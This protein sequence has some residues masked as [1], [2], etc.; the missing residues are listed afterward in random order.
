MSW[1]E[2]SLWSCFQAS[3]ALDLTNRL[4][5]KSTKRRRLKGTLRK[6]APFG[7]PRRI[8]IQHSKMFR[9]L[10]AYNSKCRKFS[11]CRLPKIGTFWGVGWRGARRGFLRGHAFSECPLKSP[12]FGTFLGEA[13]KVH[14]VPLCFAE[15][16]TFLQIPFCGF[17]CGKGCW[18]VILRKNFPEVL[19]NLMNFLKSC[20]L[21]KS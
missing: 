15:R 5:K 10:N 21:R 19:W 7:I 11:L 9:F 6:C 14:T 20:A 16:Y 13:R 17:S 18:H 4:A 12:S 8:A 2:N 1:L 3:V